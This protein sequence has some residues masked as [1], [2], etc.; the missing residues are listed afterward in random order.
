VKTAKKILSL[1]KKYGQIDVNFLAEE[2][3]V[4]RQYIHRIINELEEQML[5]K[6]TGVAPKVYYS[7]LEK[8]NTDNTETVSYDLEVFLQKHFI[9]IDAL[10]NLLEGYTAFKHWC[11]K[12]NLPASKTIN[13]FV[14]TKNKYLQYYNENSLIEG[15]HKLTT[16]KGIG[17]IGV[18]ALLYLDFYAIER[19]GKTR[20]GTLMHYAKQGQNKDLMKIIA[21]EI[22]QRI[23]KLIEI[24][25]ITAILYVPPT[26]NRRVQIMTVLEKQLNIE[27]PKIKIDKIKTKIIVP[28][29]ALSKLYERVENAKN[30][31]IV[32]MQKKHKHILIIDDAIGSGATIN[33]IANK[34][35]EK[36]IATKI[37]GLA[38][39]GSFKGFDVISEI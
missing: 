10:G 18:D 4:S 26:I 25:N 29:K 2:L 8:P 30:T 14:D 9:N 20:L 37:T 34:I 3:G 39:T 21:N 31:F 5:I 27:L 38:I 16:T 13:E 6:K 22:K 11:N 33:E 12:Q 24:E 15:L 32:P 35:K 7:I 19:F 17:K 36:K 23:Y 1:L 28:Q